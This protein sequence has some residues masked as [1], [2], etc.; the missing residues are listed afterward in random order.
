MRLRDVLH[1]MLYVIETPY[2]VVLVFLPENV[3]KKNRVAQKQRNTHS[4]SLCH[5]K[6]VILEAFFFNVLY[7]TYLLLQV[8]R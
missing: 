8:T 5:F 1:Y 7:K 4:H 3:F 6:N 2:C